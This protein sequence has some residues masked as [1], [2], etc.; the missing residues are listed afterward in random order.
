[1]TSGSNAPVA[2]ERHRPI[3]AGR[4]RFQRYL[5]ADTPA[6]GRILVTDGRIQSARI[7]ECVYHESLVHPAMLLHP[8]PRS[9]LIVGGAEGA[10]L[11][12][13]LRHPS[14]VEA[15]MVDI[16]AELVDLCRSHLPE[17]SAGA[18][19]DPRASLVTADGQDY[20]RSS[21]HSFDVAII[22]IS[23][24]DEV[25]D[26]A[27]AARPLYSEAFFVR[28]ADHLTA[29]GVAVVQGQQLDLTD[30]RQHVATRRV[31]GGVFPFL[32]S[33]S[34]Y[35]PSF[36]CE[37]GFIVASREPLALTRLT[38][39]R[40]DASLAERGLLGRLR[41]YDGLTHQ[42]MASLPRALRVRLG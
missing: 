2:R 22:D 12:E 20:V 10:T 19:D 16:D 37:W 40:V 41:H 27:A 23:D 33:Y 7:D 42:R 17:W 4:T 14:V 5:I 9:V 39:A 3:A 35:V 13:V 21:T 34:T 32:Y 29:G 15:V 31:V 24:W 38:P 28:V 18:F 11:R 25:D 30:S 6:F 8:A 1:M 26:R 36:R